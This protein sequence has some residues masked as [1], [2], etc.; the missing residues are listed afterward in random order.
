MI[1]LS[2]I[3]YRAYEEGD[4]PEGGNVPNPSPGSNPINLAAIKYRANLELEEEE[5]E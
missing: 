1:D 5:E 2:E 4:I 3:L